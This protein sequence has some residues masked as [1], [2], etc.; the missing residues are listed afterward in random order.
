MLLAMGRDD[1][2]GQF[3]GWQLPRF[4]VTLGKSRD[5]LVWKSWR[6]MEQKQP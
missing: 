5:L 2:V 6:E 1:G 4:L 3:N